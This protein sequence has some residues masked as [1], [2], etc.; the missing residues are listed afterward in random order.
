MTDAGL[1]WQIALSAVAMCLAGFVQGSCG[2]G[3][4]LVGVGLAGLVV[5]DPRL[6]MIFP[7]IPTFVVTGGLFARFYRHVAWK[8]IWPFA[9]AALCGIPLGVLFLVAMPKFVLNL[10]LGL[11]LIVSG[12]YPFTPWTGARR[13]HRFL[14]GTPLGL[15]SGLFSG[16]FSSGGP[17]AVAYVGN[18]RL[19]RYAYVATLQSTFVLSYGF[20]LA[21]LGGAGLLTRQVMIFALP[22]IPAALIGCLAGLALLRWM[23]RNAFQTYVNLLE[24]A[25]GLFFLTRL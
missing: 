10:G 9:A 23:P 2:F 3:L 7:V 13:W 15:V 20:R 16:A 5:P 1:Q 17:V 8:R 14:V 18:Q 25:L 22:G 24:I 12:S 21:V 4:G 19:E 6:A 11:L